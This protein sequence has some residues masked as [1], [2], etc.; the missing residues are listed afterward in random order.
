MAA[1]SVTGYRGVDGFKISD[2]TFGTAVPT[3]SFDWEFR[4][5]TTDANSAVV[6]RK[7]LELVFRALE[8][9]FASGAIFKNTPIL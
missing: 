1:V 3:A 9:L 6:T 7:D 5:N 4:F 8:R 2:F